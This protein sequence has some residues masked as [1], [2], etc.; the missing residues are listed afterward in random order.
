MVLQA[1][2]TERFKITAVLEKK[3]YGILSFILLIIRQN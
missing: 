1:I 3:V 2:K